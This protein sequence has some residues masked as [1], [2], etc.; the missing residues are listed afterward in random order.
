MFERM[1]LKEYLVRVFSFLVV[2][3]VV[4][5][6]FGILNTLSINN[7]NKLYNGYVAE[8]TRIET[9]LIGINS[10]AR[11]LRDVFLLESEQAN[12]QDLSG[13][14]NNI[15]RVSEDIDKINDFYVANDLDTTTINLYIQEFNNWKD[16]VDTIIGEMNANNKAYATQLLIEQ[17]TPTINKLEAIG[18]DLNEEIGLAMDEIVNSNSRIVMISIIISVVLFIISGMISFYI[19]KKTLSNITSPIN[20]I[21]HAMTELEQGNLG[22]QVDYNGK[23]ELGELSHTINNTVKQLKEYIDIIDEGMAEFSQNNFSEECPIQFKGDFKKIQVSIDTFRHNITETLKN[24]GV[25]TTEVNQVI[26]QFAAGS[27]QLAEGSVEQANSISEL[28]SAIDNMMLKIA[29]TTANT[30]LTNQLGQ[31][32][33]YIIEKNNQEI[34]NVKA[35]IDGIVKG[36]N[37]ISTIMDTLSGISQQTNL[38][39]LNAAIEAARAGEYGNGFAVVANEIRELANKSS[40]S[41][42]EVTT[43]IKNTLESVE[44][45]KV[46]INSTIESFIELVNK[47]NNIIE[48]IEGIADASVEQDTVAKEISESVNQISKV[49]ELNAQTTQ[50]SAAT[51][52]E[53]SAQ[54]SYMTDLVG[55][56]RLANK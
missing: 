22:I 20:K 29:D 36:T 38:L 19:I 52:Q 4:N 46:T 2:L 40:E 15:T 49:V 30:K 27:Q 33:K 43:L 41:S 10:T 1:R 11:A 44:V 25:A 21:K 17:C 3:M 23:N 7:N 56:F 35:A 26:E 28:N 45:G 24:I 16:V 51:S 50:D 32:S 18:I 34:Q 53:I 42:N 31:D 54:A 13:L 6:V 8:H 12:N 47:L 37:E 14:E 5:S 9:T 55:Q 39:A 48:F